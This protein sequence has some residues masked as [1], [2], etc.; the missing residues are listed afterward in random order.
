MN[1]HR[2]LNGLVSLAMMTALGC[3]GGGEAP[4]KL[5]PTVELTGIV[6][7]DGKP[8]EGASV[9]FAPKSEKGY[10]G[11]VGQTDSSGKYELH[12]DIGNGESKDGIIPGDYIVYVSRMVR[13]D[14]SL[15]PADANEPPM[16]FGGRDSIPLKYSSQKGRIS[17]HVMEKGGTFD[18]KLDS[19]P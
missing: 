16:M 10:H 2:I 14:G 12:T 11:A 13:Q 5:G 1:Y 18:I 4:P 8:L 9:R 3:S 6:T 19:K 7:L 15:I 17:Y